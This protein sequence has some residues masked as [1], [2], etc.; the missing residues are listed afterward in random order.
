[1]LEQPDISDTAIAACLQA[2]FGLAIAD[3][4]FLPIGWVHNALYRVVAHGGS[5][6]LLKLRLGP[7]DEVAVAVPALLHARGIAPV[8]APLA[9]TSAGLWFRA[10]GAVWTLYPFVE[11][12]TGFEQ[13]LSQ[14]HWLALGRCMH[15]IHTTPLPAVLAERMPRERFASQAGVRVLAS[16]DWLQ[17]NHVTGPIGAQF[18]AFWRERRS[19]ILAMAER[20]GRLAHALQRQAHA[21]VICHS[22]LHARNVLVSGAAN[23]AI[24]DWDEPI[25]APKER[26]LMFIGGGIGGIW[27][28]ADE[29]ACF[30]AG[31]GPTDINMP[32]LCYYRYE[33][34]L[35]DIAECAEMILGMRGSVEERRK[36]LGIANQFL[37]GNVVEIADRTYQRL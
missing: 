21:F 10:H 3:I 28:N 22:D 16:D 7:F 31:Y 18:A 35:N 14:A 6:Y 32:A 17:R 2:H 19:A 25:L 33:R 13:A 27:N 20:T 26:D 5:A 9:T 34:I 4:T 11:G 15:M 1:M 36:A 30:Y 12:K 8:V 37:P 24:V 29:T 23:I